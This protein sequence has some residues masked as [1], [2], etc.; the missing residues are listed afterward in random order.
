MHITLTDSLNRSSHLNY[1]NL[2]STYHYTDNHYYNNKGAIE[3]YMM[4]YGDTS[5]NEYCYLLTLM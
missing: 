3:D 5:K 2:T 1:L 4:T